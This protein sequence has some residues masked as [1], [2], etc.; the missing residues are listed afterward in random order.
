M[1][2]AIA[3]HVSLGLQDLS[4]IGAPQGDF[5][6]GHGSFATELRHFTAMKIGIHQGEFVFETFG[7]LLEEKD[8]FFPSF[9]PTP[10]F[11]EIAL[12]ETN[13]SSL[14]IGLIAQ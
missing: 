8:N 5:V 12:P 9:P 4:Y 11:P 6:A 2:L 13:S 7:G 14:K 3:C 1:T 10:T